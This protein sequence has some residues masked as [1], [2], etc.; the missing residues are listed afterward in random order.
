[1][2]TSIHRLSWQHV[3]Q[4]AWRVSDH[5]KIH[6]THVQGGPELVVEILSPSTVV[7]DRVRKLWLY[8]RAGVRELWLVTP[9]PPLAEVLVLRE[10]R[11]AFHATYGEDE[12]LVSST[13]DGLRIHL[14]EVF[15]FPVPP[16]ETI[17]LVE[18]AAAP[19]PQ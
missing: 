10:G 17:Q 4:I 7:H 5:G 2:H 1:L 12:E 6:E 18:E 14:K 8:A 19:Y 9:Y 11:Y 13:F 16:D 3:H 15:A